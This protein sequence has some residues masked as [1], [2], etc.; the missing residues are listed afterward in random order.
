MEDKLPLN[1]CVKGFSEN[2]RNKKAGQDFLN[3]LIFPPKKNWGGNMKHAILMVKLYEKAILNYKIY[4][5]MSYSVSL[6]NLNFLLS[7]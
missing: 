3:C 7:N 5:P 1:T 4:F 6:Q 2:M